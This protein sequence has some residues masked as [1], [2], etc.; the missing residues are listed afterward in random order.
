MLVAVLREVFDVRLEVL[1][2]YRGV[3]GLESLG[4]QVKCVTDRAG[5]TTD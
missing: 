2:G 1:E 3:E 4:R 5:T